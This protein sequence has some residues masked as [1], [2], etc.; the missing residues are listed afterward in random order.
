[1]ML[2]DEE[3]VIRVAQMW[4]NNPYVT[5]N[6]LRKTIGCS[7]KRFE[8]LARRGLIK[9]PAKIPK[10]KAHLFSDQSKWRSFKLEGSLKRRES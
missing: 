7:E 8:D 4:E 1:M 9:Y 3:V 2:S 6:L 10:G 5:R